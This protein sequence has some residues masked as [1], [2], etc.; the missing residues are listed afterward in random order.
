MGHGA[1]IA[2]IIADFF[3]PVRDIGA[4][5]FVTRY[6]LHTMVIED[7][8]AVFVLLLNAAHEEG[9]FFSLTPCF[10]SDISVGH[11]CRPGCSP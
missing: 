7:M 1:G 3:S 6:V 10:F 8:S 11:R 9:R 5:L 4:H 2:K